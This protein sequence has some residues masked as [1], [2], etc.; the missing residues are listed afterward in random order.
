MCRAHNLFPKDYETKGKSLKDLMVAACGDEV[1]EA[2]KQTKT[3]SGPNWKPSWN[4]GSKRARPE[5]A[6]RQ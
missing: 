4:G 6:Y 2:A 3:I 1:K 5:R